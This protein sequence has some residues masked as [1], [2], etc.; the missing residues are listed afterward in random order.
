MEYLFNKIN[1][2]PK[3][4]ISFKHKTIFLYF[5]LC[6]PVFK[7]IFEHF[8]ISMIRN[9]FVIVFI[10]FL[11]YKF[12]L[13]LSFSFNFAIINQILIIRL[14]NIDLSLVLKLIT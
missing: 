10:L 3:K 13:S 14:N 9:S 8:E 11:Y 1:E 4:I 6:V 2:M 12:F 5:L 7:I